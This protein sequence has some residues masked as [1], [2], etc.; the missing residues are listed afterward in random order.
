MTAGCI[1]QHTVPDSKTKVINGYI[2]R[3][4]HSLSLLKVLEDAPFEGANIFVFIAKHK[5]GVIET[6]HSN[7]DGSIKGVLLSHFKY[8]LI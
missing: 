4:F 3:K 1:F 2:I 7:I 6:L 8:I 5:K